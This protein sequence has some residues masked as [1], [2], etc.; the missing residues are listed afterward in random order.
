MRV[1][2]S[3]AVL[4]GAEGAGVPMVN[5]DALSKAL[6]SAEAKEPSVG[7]DGWCW[8]MICGLMMGIVGT[9]TFLRVMTE[10]LK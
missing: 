9:V 10:P 5:P 8:G 7:F 4:P 1:R 2:L 6:Q 3:G